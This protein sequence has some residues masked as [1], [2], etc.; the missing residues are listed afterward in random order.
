MYSIF[1]VILPKHVDNGWNDQWLEILHAGYLNVFESKYRGELMKYKSTKE[2]FEFM[3]LH[4]MTKINRLHFTVQIL[5][6]HLI[7]SN[8]WR[9]IESSRH[10]SILSK[11]VSYLC[12]V[13][14]WRENSIKFL[15]KL[16]LVILVIIFL[17]CPIRLFVK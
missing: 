12:R 2:I 10:C 14:S 15:M 16:I 11:L 8:F 7:S 13:L 9:N 3:I 1:L 5:E 17:L 4:T 6:L